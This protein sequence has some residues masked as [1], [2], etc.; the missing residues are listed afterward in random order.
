M[1]AGWYKHKCLQIFFLTPGMVYEYSFEKIPEEA[2]GFDLM[3]P[4]GSNQFVEEPCGSRYNF[5]ECYLLSI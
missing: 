3:G 2:P 1:P 4:M 5:S